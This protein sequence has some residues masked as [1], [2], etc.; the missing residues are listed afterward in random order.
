MRKYRFKYTNSKWA[1]IRP[2]LNTL[3]FF[4]AW[5]F[6]GFAIYKFVKAKATKNIEGFDELSTGKFM[7]KLPD[8][9]E[10]YHSIYSHVLRP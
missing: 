6:A 10:R 9:F 1:Q 2:K 8:Q 4:C 5:N 3:Y 7:S